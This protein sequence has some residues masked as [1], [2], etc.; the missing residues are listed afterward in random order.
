VTKNLTII[1][2]GKTNTTIDATNNNLIFWIKPGTI[3]TIKNLNITNGTASRYDFSR[4]GGGIYNE[5]N[6]I[7]DNCILC[8]NRAQDADDAGGA[9]GS[10]ATPAGNGGAIYNKGTLTITNCDISNNHA[11]QGGDASATHKSSSGGNGGAIYNAGLILNI[12]ACTFSNNYAGRGGESSSFHDGKKGGDGGAIYN[13]GTINNIISCTFTTNHAGNGGKTQDGTAANPGEGGNGGAI[14]SNGTVTI[15]SSI[16][17]GNYAGNGGEGSTLNYAEDGG[18]GGAVYNIGTLNISSSEI[19]NGRAGNGG[20]AHGAYSAGNGGHG[21]AIYNMKNLTITNCN[22]HHNLAGNGLNGATAGSPPGVGGNGGGIY[23][24]ASITIQDSKIHDNSAGNGGDAS[25]GV[26]GAHGGHGGGIYNT[27]TLKLINTEI[28]NNTAGTGG[29]G[30]AEQNGG[31]GGYG[32]GIF[33]S[34]NATLQSS[35]LYSNTAGTSGTGKGEGGNPGAGGHGGAIFS[36]NMLTILNCEIYNNKG[37]KGGNPKDGFNKGSGGYGGA[38]YI[39]NGTA[40]ITSTNIHDNMAGTGIFGGHGG[41]IFNHGILN[42]TDCTITNNQAVFLSTAEVKEGGNGGGIYNNGILYITNCQITNNKAA[43]GPNGPNATWQKNLYYYDGGNGAN[44]GSGGGIYNTGTIT[45]TGSSISSNHAGDGGKGGDGSPCYSDDGGIPSLSTLDPGNGGNGGHGGGIYNIGTILSIT[46]SAINNNTAGKGGDG[47]S[48]ADDYSVD[49]WYEVTP[50][51]A[52]I[53]GSGGGIYSP[54]IINKIE[55]A[56]INYNEAGK[57]GNGNPV[58]RYPAGN[59]NNGG[60]GGGLFVFK[61]IVIKDSQI[62][63]NKAGDGGNGGNTYTSPGNNPSTIPGNA[64]N[65]GHGGGIYLNCTSN[66]VLNMTGT[67]MS[68]NL[69]GNGGNPGIDND[70][71]NTSKSNGGNGGNGGAFELITTNVSYLKVFIYE[72]TFTNNQAGLGTNGLNLGQNGIPGIGG[73]IHSKNF[74]YL[75]MNFCRIVDNTP[76]AF[77]MDL[78]ASYPG[79]TSLK[80]NWWGSNADPSNQIFGEN[81]VLIT[82]SPWLMLNVNAVPTSIYNSKNSTITANLIR[83]SNG[84]D[85]STYGMYVPDITPVTFKTN[86]GTVNPPSNTTT[87][88]ASSTIFTANVLGNAIVDSTIDHQTVSTSIQ[89]NPLADVLLIKNVPDEI[90]VG[91]IFTAVITAVNRGPDMAT[92]LVFSNSIPSQFEFLSASSDKGTWIYDSKTKILSWNIGNLD[93]GSSANL[94]LTLKALKAGTYSIYG[95]L[96]SATYDPNTESHTS[97]L[98]IHVKTPK[99]KGH[100]VRAGRTIGMQKTGMP[101]AVLIV[102]ILTVLG[103]LATSKIK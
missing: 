50:A 55:N 96:A 17:D 32:G 62:S 52:G 10:D 66:L 7:I 36:Q 47:G 60:N 94:N 19:K 16:F 78:N 11:G 85:T 23:N 91:Q 67:T 54:G 45:I 97:P 24:G 26:N 89:V 76:Q 48:Y 56:T 74:N 4:N 53:G 39:D 93:V 18:H 72:S 82:Y 40:T 21:G 41:A 9:A 31:N 5:G 20:V 75:T 68:N 77:Y 6:L 61:S 1:G 42:L 84:E 102:G 12:Q 43:N 92:N 86:A 8:N 73:V 65:A 22:I 70:G 34:G 49:L 88:G 37:G 33:N 99:S 14:Y 103:G 81:S 3:V 87:N 44:G 13:T 25:V 2:E 35:K 58:S 27:A 28:Y 57:G 98:I 101:V 90:I 64:G 100:L 79:T 95:S 46:N 51:K 83:N 71:S 30:S 59:G 38:I 80:N 63:N 69:A 29:V 15:T